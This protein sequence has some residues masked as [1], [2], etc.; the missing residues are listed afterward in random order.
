MAKRCGAVESVA[1]VVAV[2]VLVAMTEEDGA[3]DAVAVAVI[4]GHGVL[5]ITVDG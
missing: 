3:A 5:F 4:V 2:I 1:D